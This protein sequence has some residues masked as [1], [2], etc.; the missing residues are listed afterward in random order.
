AKLPE[1]LS[2]LRAAAE[3]LKNSGVTPFATGYYEDWKLGDH[4]MN[5]AFAQQENTEAFTQNLNSGKEKISS[6]Q[7]FE[8]LLNLLDLTL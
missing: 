4:L 7:N 5:I 3:K 2:E 1:T 6:N 8:D